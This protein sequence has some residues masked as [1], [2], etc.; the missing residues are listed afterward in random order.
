MNPKAG[1]LS[2]KTETVRVEASG[3]ST[4]LSRLDPFWP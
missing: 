1:T 4:V 2:P 3:F